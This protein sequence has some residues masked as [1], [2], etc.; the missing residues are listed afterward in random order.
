MWD[1]SFLLLE[2]IVLNAKPRRKEVVTSVVVRTVFF[3]VDKIK[4]W[5]LFMIVARER[6]RMAAGFELLRERGYRVQAPPADISVLLF[7]FFEDTENCEEGSEL[8]G[9]GSTGVRNPNRFFR[10]ALRQKFNM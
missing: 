3:M 9:V 10:Y 6:C 1:G 5:H 4:D 7:I 2:M 8:V